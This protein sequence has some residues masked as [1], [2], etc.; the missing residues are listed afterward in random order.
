MNNNVRPQALLVVALP[1]QQEQVSLLLRASGTSWSTVPVQ[2]Y[3][4]LDL[5]LAE[6][7]GHVPH[8]PLPLLLFMDELD[9]AGPDLFEQLNRHPQLAPVLMTDRREAATAAQSAGQPVVAAVTGVTP[10]S[11]ADLLTIA[12][13]LAELRIGRNQVMQQ[14]EMA[15]NRFR[16]MADQFADWLWEVDTALRLAFSSSRKR[17]AQN[18]TRGM[19]F[20]QA[21]LPEERLRIEDDFA[22]LIRA[23]RPFHDRDYWAADAYGTRVCWSVSGTPIF[24][25]DGQL[26]G[27]RGIARDVSPMKVATDQL[28]YLTNHDPLTGLANRN[29]FADEL[30][31]TLRLAAREG[32]TG[33]LVLLNLDQFSLINHS[34]GHAVGDKALVHMTQILKDHVRTNDLVSRLDGDLFALILRDVRPEDLPPR[35]AQLQA[36]LAARSLPLEGITVTLNVSGGVAFYPEHGDNADDLHAN[37]LDALTRAKQRGPGRVEIYDPVDPAHAGSAERLQ[38]MEFLNTCLAQPEERVLLHFQPIIPLLGGDPLEFYE[39]LLRLRDDAGQ[40][41]PAQQYIQVAEAAGFAPRIDRLVISRALNLMDEW[42][43]GGRRVRLSLNV[44]ARSLDDPSFTPWLESELARCK[45]PHGRVVFELTETA[46]LHDLESARTLIRVIRA[47]GGQFALDDCGVGYSSLNYLR[48]LELDYIK[49]DG[50]FIRNLHTNPDDQAVV[51]ALIGIAKQKNIAT[52]AEMVE[53]AAALDMIKTL[54]IDFGQGFYFSPPAPD[55]VQPGT[56][57]GHPPTRW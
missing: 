57:L 36:T 8:A 7:R 39:V 30:A 3:E 41:I 38:W 40:A 26:A 19:P 54:E 16:D 34:H 37:A 23:P 51:K 18:A 21:F 44:S 15:E 22:D 5:A 32:R 2:M 27:F 53:H 28:Y 11:L 43:K 52:I 33:A 56:S 9:V 50:T 45:L 6:V 12:T 4:T 14:W 20:T 49:I 35:L 31:R 25:P 29:R 47:H 13:S 24:T 17:P 10:T 55:L 48:E 42:L 46:L 1:T